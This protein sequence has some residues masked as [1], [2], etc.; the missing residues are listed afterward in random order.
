M[1]E[2]EFAHSSADGT[3]GHGDMGLRGERGRMGEDG[4]VLDMA[5]DGRLMR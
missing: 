4:G 5:G 2:A 1:S 3:D